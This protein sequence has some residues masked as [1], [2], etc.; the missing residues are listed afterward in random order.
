M[1]MNL[2]GLAKLLIDVLAFIRASVQWFCVIYD[3]AMSMAACLLVRCYVGYAFVEPNA[4]LP[5][6][7][8]KAD[9]DNE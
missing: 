1:P 3:T 9:F 5:M 6:L 7:I 8:C 2:A 4:R